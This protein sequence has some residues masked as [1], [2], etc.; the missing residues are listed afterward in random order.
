[1]KKQFIYLPL[2]FLCFTVLFTA[3]QKDT[4]SDSTD[5]TTEVSTH[6]D[7]QQQFSDNVDATSNDVN[8][9]LEG[10]PGFTGRPGDIQTLICNAT[11]VVDTSSNPRTVTITYNGPDCLGYT[12]R[13]GVV[14]L[15]MP[16]NI[17]WRNA[18][19]AITVNIQNLHITR[20]RDNKSITINGSEV[21]TNVSGGLLINLPTLGSITHSIT[22]NGITVTFDNGTQRSWQVA[23]QRV[24][25]YNNGIVITSSGTHTEGAVTN[26]AEWGTNRFGR[27][28]TTSTE[29]PI[30]IRQDCNGRITSGKVK[31][32][33]S[34]VTA[35]AT[36]GLDVNGNPTGCPGT[37]NY[38][39][40]IEWTGANGNSHSVI[41]PY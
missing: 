14:I 1:M 3:C 34:A 8:I 20:V 22:S 26:V 2:F 11:V 10:N 40:K 30:V 38:Y 9:A 41:L 17:R 12:T 29:Q 23:K 4:N 24:F 21:Y 6:S 19:A 15:S 18:G 16:A 32:I 27:S 31:H 35:S 13:T 5:Y 39:M 33:T 37:G 36:F 7:D 25:T 28:F